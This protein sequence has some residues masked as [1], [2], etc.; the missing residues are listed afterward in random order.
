MHNVASDCR[1]WSYKEYCSVKRVFVDAGRPPT[2]DAIV[3]QARHRLVVA[4]GEPAEASRTN[5]ESLPQRLI[6]TSSQR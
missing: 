2:M 1:I 6:G 4:Q 5:W 3:H